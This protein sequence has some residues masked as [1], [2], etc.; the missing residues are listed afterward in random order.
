MG[1]GNGRRAARNCNGAAPAGV[2]NWVRSAPANCAAPR[3]LS[4]SSG[5]VR[6]HPPGFDPSAGG[7]F[8]HICA[9]RGWH[10]LAHTSARP[11]LRLASEPLASNQARISAKP[12]SLRSKASRWGPYDFNSPPSV[13]SNK[14]LT[15]RRRTAHPATT[16]YAPAVCSR[17]TFVKTRS[18]GECFGST[19]VRFR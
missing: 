4:G 7:R 18:V 17:C 16:R 11:T 5:Q 2:L 13:A 15:N 19:L 10:S 6:A 8:G 1:A 9:M 3:A 12:G 14:N